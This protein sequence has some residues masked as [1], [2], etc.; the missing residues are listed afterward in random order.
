MENRLRHQP[1]ITRRKFDY[2]EMVGIVFGNTLK[3]VWL[4]LIC[5]TKISA[6][7][8]Y[9][10]VF[11]SSMTAVVP[12]VVYPTCNIYAS[13]SFFSECRF[14]YWFWLAVFYVCMMWYCIKGLSE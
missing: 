10:S 13:E 8:G 4:F 6:G 3:K 5:A 9:C 14:V 11:A 1:R 2:I 12:T 7:V